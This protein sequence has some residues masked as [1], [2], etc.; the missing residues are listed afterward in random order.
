MAKLNKVEVIGKLQS[1]NKLNLEFSRDEND[2][3]VR[4]Y[5]NK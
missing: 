4:E 3:Y 5:I 2:F 1:L